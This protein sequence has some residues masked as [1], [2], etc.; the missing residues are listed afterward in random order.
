MSPPAALA[1]G[2]ALERLRHLPFEDLHSPGSII[3]ARCARV[4]PRSCSA[5]ARPWTRWSPS[6]SAWRRPPAPFS[7]PAP[8]RR[9]PRGSAPDFPEPSGIR[10]LGPSTCRRHVRAAGGVPAPSSS[11][12]PAPATCRLP[13]RPPSWPRRS[14]TAVERLVDVGVA[15]LHRLL[16]AAEQ[17]QR[18]RVVIVVAGMEGALPSV[19]GGW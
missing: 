3:T 15:G 4:I 10:W 16:A 9:W 17:I 18:A 19:V 13:R 11:S 2:G 7:A 5:R 6:A 14:A 8:T 1:P 12:P